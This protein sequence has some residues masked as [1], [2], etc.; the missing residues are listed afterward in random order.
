[1]SLLNFKTIDYLAHKSYIAQSIFNTT[2]RAPFSLVSRENP[3]FFPTPTRAFLRAHRSHCAVRTP[4]TLPPSPPQVHR[5]SLCAP[6]EGRLGDGWRRL[7]NGGRQAPGAEARSVRPRA[8]PTFLV[9]FVRSLT[10][11]SPYSVVAGQMRGKHRVSSPSSRGCRRCA[12]LDFYFWT[13]VLGDYFE[14]FSVA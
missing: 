5:Y 1:L 11:F 10:P 8:R 6:G 13:L 12:C 2:T 9:R 3:T 7:H 4:Q 14:I